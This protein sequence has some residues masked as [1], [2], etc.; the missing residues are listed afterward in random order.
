M[1]YKLIQRKNST[2]PFNGKYVAKAI[3]PNT[4]TSD[5]IAREIEGRCAASSVDVML[6]LEAL[7]QVLGEHLR[8]G[9][10]VELFSLG[11]FKMELESR[12]VDSPEDFSPAE[13][14][15]RPVL[16]V[17]PRCENGKP[18]IYQGIKYEEWKEDYKASR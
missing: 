14:I 15:R 13:H 17:L 6:V 18:E 7:Q 4:V 10:K 1:K 3:H 9:D 12:A 16:H 8:Q 2:I 11:T 5:D